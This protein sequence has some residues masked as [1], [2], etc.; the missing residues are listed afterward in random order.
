MGEPLPRP[1][2]ELPSYGRSLVLVV[3]GTLMVLIFL[4]QTII[5]L[6]QRSPRSGPSNLGLASI[7]PLDFWSWVTAAETASWR[8]KWIMIPITVLILF[9]SRKLYRSIAQSPARFCGVRYARKGYLASAFVPLLVLVLIGVTVPERL[10]QRQRGIDAGVNALAYTFDRAIFEYRAKFERVPN[11]LSDL[12]QLP[13][14]DGSIAAALNSLDPVA[15]PNA[16]RPSAEVA[17]KQKPRTL[18]GAVIRNASISTAADDTLSEGLSFTNYE[19]RLPG[20]DKVMGTEDDLLVRDGVITKAPQTPRRSVNST[21]ST[22]SRQ[23]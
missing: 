18:R 1:E 10:R 23:P 16:Y 9:G 15:Y 17:A 2:H 19:L 3:T 7:V 8:L 13:D 12:K 14:A 4:T 21:A 11:E 20:P 6:A 5:A 22:K